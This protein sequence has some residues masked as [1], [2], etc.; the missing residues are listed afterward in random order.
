M[1]LRFTSS[2]LALAF[3]LSANAVAVV[4]SSNGGDSNVVAL[5]NRVNSSYRQNKG[6][7]GQRRAEESQFTSNADGGVDERKKIGSDLG[8]LGI[9]RRHRAGKG[10]F[11]NRRRRAA[12]ADGDDGNSN[13]R[14]L[15]T[16]EADGTCLKPD[17]CEP[18]LCECTLTGKAYECAAEL[19][20]VCNGVTGADGTE[21]N[22]EG[23]VHVDE[24]EYYKDL[25]C[26]FAECA[27]VN[28]GTY[29][30]CGCTFYQMSC[31]KYKDDPEYMVSGL[32]NST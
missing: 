31:D 16:E 22:I 23:C 28:G 5:T 18:A 27:A 9:G 4:A 12:A 19:N 25:Y 10:L 15:V 14:F 17:T 13:L 6:G 29:G 8:L 2:S 30:S 20:A 7:N 26:S 32:Y 1:N 24:V 21:F 11:G 3:A